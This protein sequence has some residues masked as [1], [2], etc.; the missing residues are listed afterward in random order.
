MQKNTKNNKIRLDLK[1]C[2][3]GQTGYFGIR[4]TD[5]KIM[6]KE[7]GDVVSQKAISDG[8]AF[9]KISTSFGTFRPGTSGDLN[10]WLEGALERSL[11]WHKEHSAAA[12][13]AEAKAKAKAK[14]ETLAATV[15]SAKIKAE[16]AAML[17]AKE[18][19]ASG[20]IYTRPKAGAASLRTK[21]QQAPVKKG[22]RIVAKAPIKQAISVVVIDNEIRLVDNN[23]K[24]IQ[25]I[26]L[27]KSP[28]AIKV[29]NEWLPN[30]A[31]VLW[32]PMDKLAAVVADSEAATIAVAND[33]WQIVGSI[34][35]GEK[36]Y[37]VY[38]D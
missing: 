23:D 33:G 6:A 8:W 21:A 22:L 29:S 20:K 25:E 14:K 15:E 28:S 5:A 38:Y 27:V 9:E 11:L 7:V 36:F 30:A 37:E 10:T 3:K 2:F 12:K 17:K 16:A 34:K 24:L 32:H 31:A 35:G 18:A 1:V 26:A 13:A 4:G 19:A